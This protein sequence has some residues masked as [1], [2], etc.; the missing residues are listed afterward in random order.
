MRVFAALLAVAALQ[1]GPAAPPATDFLLSQFGNYLDALRVQAAIPGMAAVIVG[2]VDV[3]WERGFGFQDVEAGIAASADT[4]FQLDGVTEILSSA[5]V[6][7]C[8]EQGLISL[9]DLVG[10]YDE[11]SPDA[12]ETIRNI[13]RHTSGPAGAE[14]Y[15]YRPERL[16]VLNRVVRACTNDS[17]RETLANTAAQVGMDDSMPGLDAP[18][19][20]PP[21]EGIPDAAA[22]ERYT[23]ILG[24]LAVPYAIDFQ[25]NRARSQYAV[26]TLTPSGGFIA[27]ARDLA[28][29][30]L[31]MKN[32]LLVR[33]DTRA[34][35]WQVPV[36]S[37]GQPLPYGLGWYVQSYHGELV[38]WQFGMI[39][40]AASSM[41]ITVPGR[42]LTL[43]LLANSD[44]LVKPFALRD[45]D[46]TASLFARVFLGLFL[47]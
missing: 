29:F 4:P 22:V 15:A 12:G 23:Q 21:A 34:L 20:V 8:A 25:G 31:A 6:L 40:Q 36:T 37:T 2:D 46:V 41:V 13:M 1:L 3:R 9:D 47:P 28:L 33:P 35:T 14:V 39:E 10:K 16:V 5:L 44:G 43:I 19:L 38:A 42:G 27:S 30:D 11:S 7:R 45:G 32:G 26:T 18:S 24:R 17:Y